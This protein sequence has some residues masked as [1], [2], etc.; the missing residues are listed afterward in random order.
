MQAMVCE[1]VCYLE[2]AGIRITLLQNVTDILLSH[3][4]L[5]ISIEFVKEGYSYYQII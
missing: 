5:N 4:F 3:C 1:M 2:L